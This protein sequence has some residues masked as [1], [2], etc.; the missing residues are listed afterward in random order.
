[1]KLL[2]RFKRPVSADP[3][4]PRTV[5][6]GMREDR[7]RF[8]DLRDA[9]VLIYWPHG[10]GDWVHLSAI[11]PLLEQSN[12]YAITRFGDDYVSVMEGNHYLTPLFSGVRATGDGSDRGARHLGVTLDQC[13]GRRIT[14]ALPEPLD[15]AVLRFAPEAL[16]WTDYPETEGKTA[17]PFHTKARNVARLLVRSERLSGFDL[18]QPLPSTIDF[19]VSQ[20]LQHRVDERLARFAPAGSR[21]AVISRA[22]VTAA[23]KNWGDGSEAAA[24]RR[25]LRGRDARWRFVSM[26]A[27]GPDD[28]TATFRALFD[29]LHEPFARLFKALL[30]RVELAVAVPAGP[31]HVA[32]S[33]GGIPVV[34]LWLAHHP[35]WYDE[36]NP[37]AIHLVG[38]YVRDRGF[39]RRPATTTKPPSLQHR[40]QYLDTA[41]VP[42]EAVLAAVE[43]LT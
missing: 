38:R 25:A 7:G 28:A 40:L 30:A 14:L 27:D 21:I 6:G 16:L 42:A 39:D 15:E 11:A 8:A 43:T 34:G 20:E 2:R 3:A 22:G 35:D 9:R 24:L 13:N 1:M 12:A 29:D 36:P 10:L 18:S 19:S 17:Y 33:R 37:S 32:L 4:L 5:L 26:D 41:D 31:L 23:R